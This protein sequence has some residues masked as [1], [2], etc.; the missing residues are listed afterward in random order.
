[1]RGAGAGDQEGAI[2]VILAA[3]GTYGKWSRGWTPPK[4]AK[5]REERRWRL[6]ESKGGWLMACEGERIVGVSCWRGGDEATLAL[7]MVDPEHWGEGVGR[8]LHEAS[9][10]KMAETGAKTAR[11]SVATDNERAKAFYA[12]RGWLRTDAAPWRHAWLGLRMEE[13]ARPVEREP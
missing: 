9:M 1:M 12:R 8:I 3:L 11:L 6:Q 7:L 13:Y 4:D 2:E 5:E 10:H